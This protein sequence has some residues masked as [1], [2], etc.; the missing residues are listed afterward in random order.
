MRRFFCGCG[1]TLFFGS[2]RCLSCRRE[3]GYD[4]VSQALHPLPE[5]PSLKRCGNGVQH[6]VCNWLL[7]STSKERLCVACRMNQIVP[8]L[9]RDRNKLLWSRMESAKRRLIYSLLGL[10][11]PLPNKAESPVDGLA[12]EIMSTILNPSVSTGHLNGIITVNLEEADDT[13][14]QINRQMFGERSR[15]LLG[16]FRHESGHYL[17]ARFISK[18]PS[19]DPQRLAFRETFGQDWRDYGIALSDYYRL[20]PPPD[21][22]QRFISS[23][24]ASH[25]WED[26]AETWSHYLQMVDGLETCSAMGIQTQHLNL[27][28]V[29]L[30]VHAGFL[31]THLKSSPQE[32]EAFLAMVQRWIC[33]ST[34]LNE[35]ADSFGEAHLYPFV[36]SVP[37]AQKLRLVHYFA[38]LW[39]RGGR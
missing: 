19:Q 33:V 5:A 7:D 29:T 31:S 26:W 39:G 20:G 21:W 11:I 2:V 28:L 3:V 24:S 35:V 17:W 12:F 16:H 32:D 38:G 37:I 10:G 34:V 8:D 13:Y 1:N 14:R 30:P 23:Y 27:P 9:S 22:S 18:L 36:I 4:P 25:P 15:T 6:G